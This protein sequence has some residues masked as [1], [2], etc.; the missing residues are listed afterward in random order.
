[1]DINISS[2][3]DEILQTRQSKLPKIVSEIDRWSKVSLDLKQ[4]DQVILHEQHLAEDLRVSLQ[5]INVL[6]IESKIPKVISDLSW[7][8]ER[9]SRNT[10]NIGVSGKARVGKS[11]L[12]QKISGLGEQQIPTG[13]GLPVTAVRSQI[14]HSSTQHRATIQ[15][16]SF[17]SFREE[18][19][20]PYHKELGLLDILPSTVQ[21]FQRMCY[22]ESIENIPSK[23]N[24]IEST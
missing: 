22:P 7:L 23:K 20:K 19:L 5:S 13:S 14:Y 9:F 24:I 2:K 1:M 8:K 18:I 16:H 10:I 6:S 11:T 4:L 17:V 15:F 21:D 12:L 3:I